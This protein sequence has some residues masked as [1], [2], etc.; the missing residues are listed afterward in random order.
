M[1]HLPGLFPLTDVVF[2]H[3]TRVSASAQSRPPAVKRPDVGRGALSELAARG[4]AALPGH[5][6]AGP[7]W[8]WGGLGAWRL[9]ELGSDPQ[10]GPLR[11]V[12]PGASL[13]P[14]FLG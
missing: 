5:L 13:K 4:V 6:V 11:V 1:S 14:G 7:V 3:E 8:S 10:T 12:C 9:M 2:T